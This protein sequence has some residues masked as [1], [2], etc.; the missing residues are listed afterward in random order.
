MAE[1]KRVRDALKGQHEGKKDAFLLDP[2][3]IV[4]VDDRGSSLYDKRSKEP[5]NENLVLNIMA[6][7]VHTPISVT[8][9]TDTGE[10]E[11]VVGRRRVLHNREANKRLR[12]KGLEPRWIPATVK[13]GDAATMLDLI[14]SENEHRKADSPSGRANKMQ[15]MADLGRSHEHIANQFDCTVATVKNTLS[16]LTLPASV[17]KLVDSGTISLSHGYKLTKLDPDEAKKKAE[18]LKTEAPREPGK[19]KSKSS[20]RAREIVDGKKKKQDPAPAPAVPELPRPDAPDSL[21]Q[22]EPR[23]RRMLSV[24][25]SSERIVDESKRMGAV[26]AL[27]WVLGDE[28]ALSGVAD[29][30]SETGETSGGWWGMRT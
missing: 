25:E 3:K 9:N 2:D 27:R 19:K 5:L 12:A 23:I 7:G 30:A 13:R 6:I 24:I 15:R 29:D 28:A 10:I 8:L 16:L 1:K 22:T 18:K 4:L 21:P 17:L 14:V 20:K 11:C 26:F